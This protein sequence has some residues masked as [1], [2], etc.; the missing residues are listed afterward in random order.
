MLW[1]MPDVPPASRFDGWRRT[2][3]AI[4][5]AQFLAT[6][7][8][9]LS[10]PFAP[11]Y[12]QRDLG[13][14]DPRLLRICTALFAAATPAMIALFAPLWGIVGDRHGRRLMMLRANLGAGLALSAMGFVENTTQLIAL[15]LLQGVFSG[16][17]IAAQALATAEAPSERSGTVLGTLSSV[18]F[19]AVLCGSAAGGFLAEHLGCRLV[20]RLSGVL[21]LT[22]GTCVLLLVRERHG[23]LA[24]PETPARRMWAAGWGAV[25]PLWP[26]LLALALI[27]FTRLFDKALL[28]LLVQRIVGGVKGA[29]AATGGLM[30]VAAVAGMLAGILSGRLA[31][32]LSPS[33]VALAAAIG[34]G[35]LMLLQGFANHLGVLYAAQFGAVLFAGGLEP[36]FQAWL[37][38]LTPAA[39]RGTVLG[40]AATARA[41][42]WA[43]GPLAAGALA[44]ATDLWQVYVAAAGLYLLLL[45]MTL[46][47]QRK[48]AGGPVDIRPGPGI[49][50]P[51]HGAGAGVSGRTPPEDSLP[52]K[53]MRSWR[54][55]ASS[56]ACRPATNWKSSF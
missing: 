9:S 19:G 38:R 43:G 10:T 36:A 29:S 3:G 15:R 27:T 21:M 2:V 24:R 32:R 50:L 12:M 11:F 39:M 56:T 16:T 23:T 25:R 34:S 28:P 51:I 46:W 22:A 8:F 20:F 6:V 40:W 4:A 53:R 42:G 49:Y 45:P 55:A 13:L 7:G 31:D 14:T 54:P 17:Q 48:C 35:G 52:W 26:L 30:M 33:R 37:V 18:L 41:V 1:H 44:A 5:V 47:V